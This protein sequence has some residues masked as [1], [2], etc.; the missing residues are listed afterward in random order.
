MVEFDNAGFS[1]IGD[2][3]GASKEDLPKSSTTVDG[4]KTQSS[5]PRGKRRGVGSHAPSASESRG[6]LSKQIL[7]VGRKRMRDDEDDD[8]G[9]HSGGPD[10]E[11]SDDESVAGRTG[12]SSKEKQRHQKEKPPALTTEAA[13]KK[14][15]G[16]KER[17][18]L[19]ELA[20]AKAQEL[21]SSKDQVQENDQALPISSEKAS[22]SDDAAGKTKKR[23]KIRSRQKNI[24][25]DNR[26][27]KPDHLIVG[28]KHYQGRPLTSETR[29][30]LNLPPP[31][32]RTAFTSHRASNE[33]HSNDDGMG[34]AIDDLL[35]E[36]T[37][38]TVSQPND[39]LRSK[40]T[41][42][43]KK[44]SKYKNLK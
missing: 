41:K 26:E 44:K 33:S 4:S 7:K 21:E 8:E 37:G 13:Q 20:E 22:A 35:T 24:R 29:S 27:V 18:R 11:A 15:L 32:L 3:F 6:D 34:L 23:R 10:P 19:K 14:K 5:Q 38:L 1:A 36:D 43:K 40:K 42:S 28:Q 9:S 16:K 17:Q 2:F 25:K 39:A 30:K 31:K 12:I